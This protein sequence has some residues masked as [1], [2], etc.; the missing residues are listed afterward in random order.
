MPGV[1]L[2]PNYRRRIRVVL[3]EPC[4]GVFHGYIQK[5]VLLAAR[6]S[7]MAFGVGTTGG[8]TGQSRPRV[9]GSARIGAENRGTA[10]PEVA[11]E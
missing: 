4:G 11:A 6:P 9:G 8:V 10:D 7:A 1:R 2:G 3:I 5:L